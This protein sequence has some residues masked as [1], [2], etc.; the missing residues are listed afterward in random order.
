MIVV[1]SKAPLFQLWRSSLAAKFVLLTSAIAVLIFVITAMVTYSIQ[2]KTEYERLQVKSQTLATLIASISPDRIF[3]HDYNSLYQYVLQLNAFQDVQYAIIFDQDNQPLTA[4]LDKNKNTVKNAISTVGEQDVL[5]VSQYIDALPEMEKF[6]APIIFSRKEIGTVRIGISRLQ[7]NTAMQKVLLINVGIIML[8]VLCLAIGVYLVFHRYVLRPT[9]HLM[10]GAMLVAKGD[11]NSNIPISSE[12]EL[13]RLARSFNGMIDNL[14]MSDEA[15]DQALIDLREL[16]HTLEIRVEERTSAIEEINIELKRLALYDS[17]TELPNRTLAQDRLEQLLKSAEWNHLNFVVM[18]MD[19]DRF[20]DINDTLGHQAGDQ[21]LKQIGKR[22]VEALHH[23]DTVARLG[24]D[25]FAILLPNTDSDRAIIIANKILKVLDEPTTLAGLS[26]SVAG[27]IGI[28]FY[29]EHGNDG[30]TLF[31]HADV[32]MYKAKHNKTGYCIYH[33]DIDSHKPQAFL[34]MADL[35]LAFDNGDLTL[36]YQPI[37][38]IN[39]GQWRGVEALARWHHKEIGFIPPD[40]FIPLIEQTGLIRPFTCWVID[41][42]L[43]QWAQWRS[44]GFDMSVSVNLSMRNLQDKEF[45]EQLASLLQKWSV[46]PRALIL[47]ITESGMMNDPARVFETLERFK[48]LGVELAIDDFGTG[49]SSLSYLRRLPVNEIKIDRSFV[50]DMANN[51]GDA[52]IVQSTIDLAHNLNLLVVAE[53]VED[54][55]TLEMLK[56]RGCDLAQGYYLSQPLTAADLQLTMKNRR[57]ETA[58]VIA[59]DSRK[60]RSSQP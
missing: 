38:H 37:V 53:G 13:G 33:K 27:S 50:K 36:F 24:G 55:V 44:N 52:M 28:A 17:L 39:T 31:K 42:A 40:Q 56:T 2:K 41:T 30:A 4:Y 26:C 7:A 32:A 29:P 48:H 51:P 58:K 21:L 54:A 15:R 43:N 14:R 6:I 5:K 9:Q 8:S 18:I 11:L 46:T 35:R 12:D 3:S 16:N 10:Q 22:L 49:Y 25:E 59:L 45:P 34:L 60:V 47:E 1:G 19:L 57:E 23:S 20:K